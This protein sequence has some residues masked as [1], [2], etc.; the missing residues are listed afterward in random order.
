MDV[1]LEAAALAYAEEQ[2]SYMAMHIQQRTIQDD[3]MTR[4]ANKQRNYPLQITPNT[5]II[6]NQQQTTMNVSIQSKT[7][8]NG[9]NFSKL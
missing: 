2:S 5:S 4:N 1:F 9:N 6:P 3:H 8:E 7:H